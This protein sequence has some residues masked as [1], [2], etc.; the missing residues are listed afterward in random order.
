MVSCL[1][2][3]EMR[4]LDSMSRAQLLEAIEEHWEC[5]PADLQERIGDQAT[6]NLR[7]YVLVARLIHA[8][9]KQPRRRF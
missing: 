5:L 8:L 1:C 3:M 4:C 2:E 9:R 7:L 6:S